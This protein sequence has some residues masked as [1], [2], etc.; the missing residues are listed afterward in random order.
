MNYGMTLMSAKR[1]ITGD[2]TDGTS[3]PKRPAPS[4]GYR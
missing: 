4:S 2:C 3:C 1:L